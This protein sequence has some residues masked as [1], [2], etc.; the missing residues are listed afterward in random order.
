MENQS[1]KIKKAAAELSEK[2][3]VSVDA[4]RFEL[5][6]LANKS[7]SASTAIRRLRLVIPGGSPQNPMPFKM[8]WRRV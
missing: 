1:E 6:I 5:A 2:F 8:K 4:I 3:G 7:V